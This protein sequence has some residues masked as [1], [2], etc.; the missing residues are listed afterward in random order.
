M[1]IV[2]RALQKMQQNQRSAG[3]ATPAAAASVFGTVVSAS[4]S[5]RRPAEARPAP[6][7]MVQINQAALRAAGLLAPEHQA[8]QLAQQYRQIKRPLIETAMGRGPTLIPNGHVIMTASAVPGEG[9]TFT[10]INLAFSIALEKDISVLLVDADIPKPHISRL[11]GMENEMGLLDLLQDPMLDVESLVLPTDVP[12]LSVLPAGRAVEHATEL[13]ASARMKDIV[14]AIGRNDA[15]RIALVDSPPL[16]LTTESHVLTQVVG[17]VVL[18]VRAGVTAQN[19]VL[20]ALSYL[21]EG[22]SVSLV[23]N[24]SVDTSPTGYYY[25]SGGYGSDSSA[26]PPSR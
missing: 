19:V 5:A 7:R 21:P 1:S 18:V 8:R 23:L 24:Q 14:T 2:E 4:P 15:S 12:G 10:A 9:K 17:Q 26:H 13:L 20:D 11:F 3:T 6:T 25:Y 22:K 16:L